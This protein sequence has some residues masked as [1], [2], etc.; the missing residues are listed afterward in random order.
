VRPIY[1]VG[2]DYLVMELVEGP[3]LGEHI[4]QGPLTLDD[5]AGIGRQR[6]TPL[7]PYC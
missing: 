7:S 1:D 5:A 2:P 6:P 4:S 3:T